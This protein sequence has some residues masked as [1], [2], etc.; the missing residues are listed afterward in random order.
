MRRWF[1]SYHSPDQELAERLKTGI[2]QKDKG[3]QVFF[4]P[5]NLRAGG[6]WAPALADAIEN[7]SAFVLLV[8]DSGL[9]RWQEMEYDAALDR[10]IASG[11]VPIVLMLLEGQSAPRLP[12]L[13]QLHWIVT[14]D[15]ACEKDVSRLIG[16]VLSGGDDKPR[17]LWRYTSP[18]RGLSSMEEKDSDYFFG[19]ER[20]TA[21]VL[22]V[23]SAESNRLPVLLGNSGVGKSSLAQ[24][25]VIAALRRQAWPESIDKCAWPRSFQNSRS[26]CFLAFKPGA[27]P[28]KALVDA[29]LLTWRY[30]A[31]DPG[32]EERRK[33]WVEGL[34]DGRATLPG[35]LDATERR[36]DQIGQPRPPAFFLYVDQG[37]ELYVRGERER[38]R[39]SEL[40]SDA[41]GDQRL[42]ALIS[43]RS[44]FLGQLQND[45]P[46]FAA[47]RKIDVP[48][49]RETELSRVI[50]EPAR[51]LS[52]RF[53][54]EE[55]VDVIT[56]RTLEDSAKD[57]GALPLLSYM[58]DDMWTE[59][60][61]RGD[62]VLRVPAGAFELGGVLAE[63]ANAFLAR[64][65]NSEGALRRILT[66]RL[67][68][69][70]K[71]G[72]PTRR[73]ALRR[74]FSDDE[75]R[76]VSELTDHPNRLLITAMPEV[77]ETY[78][79][80]A[81]EAI[82]RRWDKLR[83]WIDSQ[84]EFLAWKLSLDDDRRRW[85]DAPS[86]S[87]D[88]ALLLGLALAQARNWLVKRG[89][90]L[91]KA[92]REFIDLSQKA[93]TD[94]RETSR[95]LEI[96]R[97][98]AEQEV[99]RLRAETEAQEQRE[100]AAREE[101]AR[102][103]AEKEAQ[104]ERDRTTARKRRLRA[105][106]LAILALFLVTVYFFYR[107]YNEVN[108]A[109]VN[110]DKAARTANY[111]AD[112]N[113]A[114]AVT[115]AQS[116]LDEVEKSLAHGDLSVNGAN[117]ML[118]VAQRIIQNAYSME[119]TV[120]T[121][122]LLIKLQLSYYDIYVALGNVGN[123]L[124]H[125]R[126][127]KSQVQALRAANP[128]SPEILQSFYASVWRLGDGI[129]YYGDDQTHQRQALAEYEEAQMVA[130]RLAEIAPGNSAH[131]RELMFISQ[132]IG[133]V[134]QALGD[135][136][137]AI[138]TYQTALGVIEKVAA[139]EPDNRAW[140]RDIANSRRR[141]G[142]VLAAT[143]NFDGALEEFNAAIEILADLEKREFRD[144]ITKANLAT[145]H[146]QVA[147]I[148]AKRE[149]WSEAA[150]E[151]AA[152]FTIQEHL[153][154]LD[155]E[156]ATWRNSLAILYMGEGNLLRRQKD[157]PSALERYQKAYNIRDWLASKD[158]TNPD[159]QNNLAKAAITVADVV[160][161]HYQTVNLD[162]VA[163]KAKLDE[164]EKLYRRAIEIQDS[165]LPRHDDD[166]FDCYIKIGD[167][168][169]SQEDREGA[170]T[171]YALAW[172]IANNI[173]DET[174]ACPQ[175]ADSQKGIP[176]IPRGSADSEG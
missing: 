124:K 18:Y 126:D 158:P 25:G 172:S 156:N 170:L 39:F 41:I 87:K 95:Q 14:R 121:A 97:V 118:Q 72:D 175:L 99:A 146:R 67:A 74:E 167:I 159:R 132:K 83:G 2:E 17:E 151:Y 102:L 28:I 103:R 140:R 59:M 12:F 152:A 46:L 70:R 120:E 42:L 78:A 91:S 92:D 20:E 119:M 36:Y 75:W 60:V 49:L 21:E 48:P 77:G 40:L 104:A 131:Q 7:A 10:H 136:D 16:A 122:T 11:D 142:Q 165:V 168:R 123:A 63:R 27:E 138:A 8:T 109:A 13:K 90:D 94:R 166:I 143:R 65:P 5:T 157:L 100:R 51:Q 133:D 54:S 9:G 89:E 69:V 93:E 101:V 112:Q 114:L 128:D 50:R 32:W 33:G 34:F 35:L 52:A 57:V 113:F 174:R 26:W 169:L 162:E 61:L 130:L 163:Q 147:E 30:D 154:A 31:T 82:F 56:R 127:A 145:V 3:A 88:D 6:R 29:F 62:G 71:E 64:N 44:D 86:T 164:A 76:L 106:A 23:L 1:L 150:A 45:E 85:D 80:V 153:I 79:E 81:H 141:I 161:A 4:A 22:T 43:M 111:I 125:A 116:I 24:A 160:T 68:T 73:R 117:Q 108:L 53:E 107:E 96:Q 15:P 19:R 55:L 144:T 134:Y 148:Y 37:E 66:I 38:P 110:A 84:R 149:D 137:K 129:S 155:P 58:L 98:R 105:A 171:A 47:H 173:V 135:Y 176:M 139:T 115:S